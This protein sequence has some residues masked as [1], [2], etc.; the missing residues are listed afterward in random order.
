MARLQVDVSEETKIWIKVKA[1]Q[2]GTN[3]SEIIQRIL[4]QVIEQEAIKD[5]EKK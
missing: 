3:Q 5:S 2:E 4:D 1:A